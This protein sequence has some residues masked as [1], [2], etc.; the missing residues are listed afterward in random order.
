MKLEVRYYDVDTSEPTVLLHDDDCIEIGVKENDRV[1]IAGTRVAVALVSRSDTLVEKG[2]I[3]MP[4]NL[5]EKCAVDEGDTVNVHYSQK[6]DSVRSIR[7]KMDGE[8][9]DRDEIYSIV[10]DILENKLSKI[11]ISAWLTSLH[12]NGMDIDEIADFT[13]AMAETGDIIKFDISMVLATV[14]EP[15]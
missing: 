12:I 10:T 6:P 3:M 13:K 14:S 8:K 4:L 9:L 5:M 2:C 7:R 1:S 11:E 15:P